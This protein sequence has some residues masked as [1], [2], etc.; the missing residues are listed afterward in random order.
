MSSEF[1]C[2]KDLKAHTINQRKKWKRTHDPHKLQV[3]AT[4]NFLT[5]LIKK[6]KETRK[7]ARK[8]CLNFIYRNFREEKRRRTRPNCC[9]AKIYDSDHEKG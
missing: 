8:Y 6:G 3:H 9:S 1:G 7:S 4:V 5:K 2:V